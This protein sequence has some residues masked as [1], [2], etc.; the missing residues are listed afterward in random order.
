M[1]QEEKNDR[2]VAYEKSFFKKRGDEL[3]LTKGVT[4]QQS[5]GERRGLEAPGGGSKITEQSPNI[6]SDERRRGNAI[7]SQLR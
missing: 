7:G 3:S 1:F 5:Q 2:P 4:V 6:F